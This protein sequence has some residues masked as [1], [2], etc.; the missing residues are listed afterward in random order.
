MS[1]DSPDAPQALRTIR[2][3]LWV[4]VV[5]LVLS[6]VTAFPLEWE[7]GLLDG[8]FGKGTATSEAFPALSEWI[9]KVHG[10]LV[11]TYDQ[12]PFIAYG[13]DW[14]AFAHLVLAILFIGPY[15]D[16]VKNIWVIQFGMI[17]CVLVIPLAMICGHIRGIPMF[18]RMVD[19]S[20]GVFGIVP[21]WVVW[22]KIQLL[23]E[24]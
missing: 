18:W 8:W 13:T 2:I 19:C 21:L 15:R 9:G 5:G 4:F 10:G 1:P 22:Q 6:G 16:P 23:Q 14:L 7:L 3:W 17:A 24:D 12:Y 11:D 20:F